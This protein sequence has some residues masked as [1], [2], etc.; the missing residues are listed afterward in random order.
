MDAETL[1]TVLPAV[2]SA[3]LFSLMHVTFVSSMGASR[4]L[5]APPG[6]A[7]AGARARP[8]QPW[9]S[10][11]KPVAGLD[12]GLRENLES[13]AALDYPGYEL[14]IGVAS[15]ADPAV[16]VVEAFL[17]AHPGLA[18]RL[19][20]TKPP[21]GNVLNP[22]VAQLIGLARVARGAVFVISDAN[23]RVQKTYLA[24]L[25]S[26]LLA[27]GVGLASSVVVGSGERTLGAAIDTLQMST[28]VS[29]G[30]VASYR[31]GLRAISVGKSMAMRRADLERIGGFESVADVLA[32]D[33]ALGQRFHAMGYALA[34]CM[35]PVENYN[36]RASVYRTVDRYGRWAKMRRWITPGLFAL[37]VLLL[38]VVVSTLVALLAPS[39]RAYRIWLFSIGLSCLG[40]LLS[41]L[42]TGARRPLLL[43][44]LEPL[45]QVLMFACWCIGWLQ[46]KV[47]WRGNAFTLVSGSRLVPLSPALESVD[48]DAEHATADSPFAEG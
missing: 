12:E 5:D 36:A 16:P 3:S 33:D 40:A 32:E 34:V 4:E 23:V 17:A 20:L 15:L 41:L 27:P 7:S 48:V 46:R 19:V 18:A 22:K 11:L 24:S 39:P 37:E 26:T 38:P 21:S 47:V 8:A 42:R 10:I 44:A 9:V 1:L 28:Y 13:F 6:G 35:E 14:L 43:A 30:V 25:V 45:R 2:V 29:P 31:L